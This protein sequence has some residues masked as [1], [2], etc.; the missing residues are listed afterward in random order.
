MI[1]AAMV[2][3]YAFAIGLLVALGYVTARKNIR[4]IEAT[5]AAARA[6]MDAEFDRFP[7][8]EPYVRA[9]LADADEEPTAGPAPELLITLRHQPD[10]D[11]SN[12]FMLAARLIDQA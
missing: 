10:T 2:G 5:G 9:P 12:R 8:L 3:Y 7:P 11:L 4:A 1:T 6:R